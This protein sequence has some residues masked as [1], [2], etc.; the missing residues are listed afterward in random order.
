MPQEQNGKCWPADS[1]T[2]VG[3]EVLKYSVHMY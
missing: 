1:E 2:L 3:G